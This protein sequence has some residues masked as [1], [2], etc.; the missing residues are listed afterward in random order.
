VIGT[1]FNTGIIG[2]WNKVLGWLHIS[3]LNLS[4]LKLLESGGHVPGGNAGKYNRPTA[5]VGEGNPNYPEYVIPTDPKYRSRA[6]GL[7]QAAGGDLSMLESGGKIQMMQFGGILSGIKSAASKVLSVGKAALGLIAN[8]AGI[9]DSLW[10]AIPHA[11]DPGGATWQHAIAQV[12]NTIINMAKPILLSV[13][14]AFASSFGGG[15]T[16]VVRKART[17][18]GVPY[19]WGGGGLGGPSYGI[20]QGANIFGFDC[21]GLTEYA[22]GANK[23]DIGGVTDSQWASSHQIAPGNHPGA[24][25]FPSGPSVHVM[26]ASDKPGMVIQAPHTGAFV[27]EVSR[28][29]SMWRWPN[30]AKM[31]AGGM[32][33]LGDAFTKGALPTEIASALRIA[34]FAGSG[35]RKGIFDNGGMAQGWPFNSSKPEAVLTDRQWSA[36]SRLAAMAAKPNIGPINITG[37]PEIPSDKQISNGIDRVL[38]MHGSYWR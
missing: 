36:I 26:L 19:S 4:P 6:A 7:W 33:G 20:A 28:S 23:I 8:P 27:E 13:V 18:L 35:P 22:W 14:K 2:L 10:S 21:S 12:P 9:L 37:L 3:G 32:L 30:A 31:A 29:A 15:A 16:G 1:V 34:G 11:S 17:Q 5:I 38:T 24:L 25:L